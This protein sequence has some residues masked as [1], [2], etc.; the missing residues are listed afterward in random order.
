MIIS[1]K[2]DNCMYDSYKLR[3][4]LCYNSE[5]IEQNL[6]IEFCFL[7]SHKKTNCTMNAVY[8]KHNNISMGGDVAA[9]CLYATDFGFRYTV[10][11]VYSPLQIYWR[12][13]GFQNWYV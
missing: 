12:Y 9:I 10:C 7:T 8:N 4:G 13:S 11:Y 5:L 1:V 6:I 3:Q 2:T